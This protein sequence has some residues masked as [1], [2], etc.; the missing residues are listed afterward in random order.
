MKIKDLPGNML[1][2]NVR[3]ILPQ[4]VYESSS[5]PQSGIKNQ[6]VYLAGGGYG[7]YWVRLHKEDAQIY[8]LFRTHLPDSIGEWECIIDI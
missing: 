3:V 7:D 5:L 6:P 1:M 4:D 8:P 2:K